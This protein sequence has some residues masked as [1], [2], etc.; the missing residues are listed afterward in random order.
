MKKLSIAAVAVTIPT[1][2]PLLLTSGPPELPGCKGTLIW[3]RDDSPPIPVKELIVPLVNFGSDPRILVA[4]YPIVKTSMPTVAERISL[5]G[6]NARLCASTFNSAKSV[7]AL[8]ATIRLF[9]PDIDLEKIRPKAPPIKHQAAKGEI[10]RVLLG[11]LRES[12]VPVSTYDLTLHVMA[13]RG[14]DTSDRKLVAIMRKR[15][16][17]VSFSFSSI[18]K[19]ST[20]SPTTT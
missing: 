10:A 2:Y 19:D 6:R 8:D 20:P 14:L 12:P 5:S 15:A 7:D 13:Q 18:A 1:T 16:S 11:T 4:G 3:R 17:A 9:D